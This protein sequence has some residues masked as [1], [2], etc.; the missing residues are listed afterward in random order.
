[1]R[2]KERYEQGV[3]GVFLLQKFA[4]MAKRCFSDCSMGS[5]RNTGYEVGRYEV[6]SK[7]SK[8]VPAFDFSD[9]QVPCPKMK[10]ACWDSPKPL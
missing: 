1:M 3:H 2:Y 8:R 6:G 9:F 4:D 5:G 7:H 10:N